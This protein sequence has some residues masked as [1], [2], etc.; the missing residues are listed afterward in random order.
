MSD[1][2]IDRAIFSVLSEISGWRKVAL[3]VAK[4]AS[5]LNEG[6]AQGDERYETVARRIE[7]LVTE[8]RLVAQ[9]NIKNWRSSEVRL[10]N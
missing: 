8:G 10:P 5:A 9:G 1:I 7:L 6:S 2:L 3:V 4:V